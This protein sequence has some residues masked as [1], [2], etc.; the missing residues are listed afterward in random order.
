MDDAEGK[1]DS[2]QVVDTIRYITPGG[3][4]LYGGGGIMP[5]V[6]IVLDTT[7]NY[8]F[9]NRMVRNSIVVE[10]AIDYYNS[11]RVE[12]EKFENMQ[13]FG[14]KMVLK[15]NVYSDLVS[16]AQQQK[17]K[18]SKEEIENSKDLIIN[19]LKAELARLLF[20]EKAYFYIYLQEDEV[21]NKALQEM[22]KPLS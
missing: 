17:L 9:Y 7:K 14:N 12:L 15:E 21:F 6:E 18:P 1:T 8:Y 4:V 22:N 16:I 13:Q 2:T 20:G 11:H 19:T 5:D 3:R 10:Y